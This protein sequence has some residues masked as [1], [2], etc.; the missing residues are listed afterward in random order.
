MIEARELRIGSWVSRTDNPNE[1]L[2]QDLMPYVRVEAISATGINAVTR[3]DEDMISEG[4]G[5]GGYVDELMFDQIFPIELTMDIL[6]KCETFSQELCSWEKD[7]LPEWC[8]LGGPR[9][10][11]LL[12]RDCPD[13]FCVSVGTCVGF[14]CEDLEYHLDSLHELQNWYQVLVH[15]ELEIN[16]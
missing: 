13:M 1:W 4:T 16:L 2:E 6:A 10:K 12:E 5:D 8:Y 14:A 3:Y 11:L 7:V 15:Q 9:Y